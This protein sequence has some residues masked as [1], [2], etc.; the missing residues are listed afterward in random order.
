MRQHELIAESM[1]KKSTYKKIDW[2][3]F[4]ISVI[5]TAIGIA[6]TFIVDGMLERR[7]KAQAQRLTAI[8]VIHDIDNSID[9]VKEMREEEERNGELLR[10]A[11]KQRDHLEGMPFDTLNSVLVVLTDS[12]S[13]FSFDTSKEKIFNSDL[14][15]WQN[16]GNMA[17]LDNVQSFY[18]HRQW[19]QDGVNQSTMWKKPISDEEYM[20][21]I[22][23]TG[24]VTREAYAAALLP[25][26]KEKLYSNRVAYYINISSG[27]IDYLTQLIDYWTGLND[28]NKF[29]MGIADQELEDYVSN[30]SKKGTP[31]KRSTLLGHWVLTIGDQT[32]E[33]DFHGDHSYDFTIDYASAFMKTM[34]FSG[35]LKMKISYGGDWSF[36][37]DSLVLT[38][39]YNTVDVSVD[40]SALV[41]DENMQ[42]SL[43]AWVI[44]YREQTMDNF[45]EMA[46]KGDK[47]TFKALLDSSHD[48]MEWTES[49]GTVR[50]LKR[51]K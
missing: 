47:R 15:T 30:I 45:K 24:W 17:F 10:L 3:E 46:D 11:L 38:P 23:G 28:E 22:M 7:N 5:G 49:D 36:Q 19:F 1:E 29:L 21:F 50:Y 31:L 44:R 26:L 51:K 27:R 9:I 48:K 14:D 4:F 33:Y 25:L 34:T 43:D 18:H 8:M 32:N 6:I 13:E 39:N 40:P 41:P 20:Q 37:G 42:D 35:R 16:L 2:Q 12:R